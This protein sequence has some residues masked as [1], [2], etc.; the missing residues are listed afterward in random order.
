MNLKTRLAVFRGKLRR[1]HLVIRVF[2]GIEKPI[3][4]DREIARNFIGLVDTQKEHF[5]FT[6]PSGTTYPHEG[7]QEG[8]DAIRKELREQPQKLA[9]AK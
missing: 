4:L 7:I 6:G 3:L 8:I 5:D 9:I 1:T 2:H